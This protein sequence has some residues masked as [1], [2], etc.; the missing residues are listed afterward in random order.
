MDENRIGTDASM[1]VHV[2][3]IVDR[4]YVILCDET[5]TPIRPPGPPGKRKNLPR[6][7]GRYLVPTPLG[8]SLLE[9][10]SHDSEVSNDIESPALLS[11]PSIRRQMEE[12]VKEIA[13]GN[14]DK[15]AA[16]IKNLDWFE[17]R[18]V[19]M[20]E[21]LTRERVGEFGNKLASTNEHLR[22]LQKLDAFEPKL[23]GAA[24][25]SNKQ[26]NKKKPSHKKRQSANKTRY[27]GKRGG[28]KNTRRKG[29]KIN[30]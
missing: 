15:D 21:S 25:N 2:T 26:H 22:Y 6:Q 19:E 23:K 11:H 13:K 7:V 30:Q 17:D 9:L 1:A 14:I 5:G 3:N 28:Q 8:S 16:L 24:Q 4:G 12:E 29:T 18:Y 10:F 27:K 20:E